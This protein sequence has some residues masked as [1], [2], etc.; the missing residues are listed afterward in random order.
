MLLN[1][2]GLDK[3]W[4][5]GVKSAFEGV[6]GWHDAGDA[7]NYVSP[8]IFRRVNSGQQGP[9]TRQYDT[10]AMGQHV[11][12]SFADFVDD[13]DTND[14]PEDNDDINVI[15]GRNVQSIPNK[16]FRNLLVTNFHK[17]WEKG[18]IVWPSRTGV[19]E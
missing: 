16:R 13:I 4:N 19:M 7:E 14:E 8:L 3:Q 1:V 2:D 6:L 15:K 9:I 18:Q 12:T 5:K 10:S 17:Q 11:P